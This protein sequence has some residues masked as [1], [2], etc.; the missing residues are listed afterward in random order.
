MPRVLSLPGIL[1]GLRTHLFV[2]V[3]STKR[4]RSVLFSLPSQATTCYY[5]SNHLK[6]EA[7]SL[8]ALPKDTS[9]LTGLSPSPHYPF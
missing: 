3:P 7:I 2:K 1:E 8:S 6:V 9:E 4:Q 5:Q